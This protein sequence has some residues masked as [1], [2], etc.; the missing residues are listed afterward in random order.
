MVAPFG[1]HSFPPSGP[2]S[3]DQS[4][5]FVP[6]LRPELA[7]Q[8]GPTRGLLPRL[9]PCAFDD[10][11]ECGETAEPPDASSDAS[12]P[13][14]PSASARARPAALRGWSGGESGADSRDLPMSL[15]DSMDPKRMASRKGTWTSERMVKLTTGNSSGMGSPRLGLGSPTF[16]MRSSLDRLEQKGS[17]T[18]TKGGIGA[19]FIKATNRDTLSQ[20]RSSYDPT[21]LARRLAKCARFSNFMVL[22]VIV[23]SICTCMDIDARAAVEDV[24]LAVEV[25]SN[26]ALGLYTVE[27]VVVL[28]LRGCKMLREVATWLDLL[29]IG[30]GAIEKVM[31][32]IWATD[33]SMISIIRV[34]RLVRI[35]RITRVLQRTRALRELSKLVSMMTTCLKALIWSFIFCFVIMT[36]WAMLMVEFIH[37]LIQELHFEENAFSDCSDCHKATRSVMHAN[38]LLFKT[39]I[40][41]DSWGQIAV[42]VIDEYPGTAIIFMG[43][44][45]TLVFGVLNLIVAVVVDT[46]AEARQRDVLNLA[47][48]LEVDLANDQKVLQRMFDRIDADGSGMLNFE[49]LVE[50][51]RK[52]PEFQSRLRVMDIDESD[53]RQL[54][55]MIDGTGEGEIQSAEFIAAL[56]RWV[57]DSKTAPRF[58]K[59][60]MLRSLQM[61]EDLYDIVQEQFDILAAQIEHSNLC[62]E[63]VLRDNG[64]LINDAQFGA[65]NSQSPDFFRRQVTAWD[66]FE[67]AT[68]QASTGGDVVAGSTVGT[69]VSHEGPSP[70]QPHA[71]RKVATL[72]EPLREAKVPHDAGPLHR[73]DG[74]TARAAFAQLETVVLKA[75]EAALRRSF[76]VLEHA[77]PQ[78]QSKGVSECSRGS[79]Q[80]LGDDAMTTPNA[81][82]PR[83]RPRISVRHGRMGIQAVPSHRSSSFEH[84][85]T[86]AALGNESRTASRASRQSHD[87]TRPARRLVRTPIGV[88]SPPGASIG[89]A[90]TEFRERRSSNP[91]KER[92][93]EQVEV[94][95]SR[96]C[97]PRII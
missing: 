66:K 81:F 85:T 63:Q 89:L 97:N 76:V 1:T 73:D 28:I 52:D 25:L 19:N 60:N 59:Y 46:F 95:R 65:S 91:E 13:S 50:G 55:D 41:G 39:V 38:V 5:M 75:T 51:A 72:L 74:E 32:V 4:L 78:L 56:S 58:V 33:N 71:S 43:S 45:L 37:P 69:P 14:A 88:F 34:L 86:S 61:Q 70:E 24:P 87:H 8:L 68:A 2:P 18:K 3:V 35:F 48:D 21:A 90:S 92:E 93:A 64:L 96:S 62:F 12:A 20:P 9:R 11:M 49:E 36:V 67:E 7:L 94:T 82:L 83:T 22:V 84:P 16:S 15:D 42:P 23:D 77:L 26:T 17:A 27:F 30:C 80:S 6:H 53:L 31:E 10:P 40:A 44:L 54:F 47:E 79:S 29:I 57:H